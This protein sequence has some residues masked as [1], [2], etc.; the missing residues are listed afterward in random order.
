MQ[1]THEGQERFGC[2]SLL[3]RA[4]SKANK[5]SKRIKP[6]VWTS[7]MDFR[8]SSRRLLPERQLYRSA[9]MVSEAVLLA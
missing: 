4:A 5:L 7:Q 2:P 3:V 9:S 1:L 8:A 6:A